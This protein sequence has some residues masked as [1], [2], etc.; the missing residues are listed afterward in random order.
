M[1]VWDVCPI[2]ETMAS[3]HLFFIPLS[4]CLHIYALQTNDP[5]GPTCSCFNLIAHSFS[6]W[7]LM[8]AFEPRHWP[9]EI[10]LKVPALVVPPLSLALWQ[11]LIC[12]TFEKRDQK[13][14]C[15][16]GV[17]CPHESRTAMKSWASTSSTIV[18]CMHG[19][20]KVVVQLLDHL[21]P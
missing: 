5:T 9:D 14:E 12:D 11:L 7:V 13:K 3:L 20:K 19:L 4:Y 1:G 15:S 17:S 6:S 2:S 21:T 8:K 10:C 18:I 16:D